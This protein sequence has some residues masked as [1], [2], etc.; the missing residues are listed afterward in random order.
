[1]KFAQEM[2]TAAF[3]MKLENF[4]IIRGSNAAE[5]SRKNLTRNVSVV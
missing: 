4:R 2:E 1:M 3:V 5:F